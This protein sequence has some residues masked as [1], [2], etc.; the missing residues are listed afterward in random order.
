M[1]DDVTDFS[2]VIELAEF[3]GQKRPE[4]P[5]QLE[6]AFAHIEDAKRRLAAAADVAIT[7]AFA[8]ECD[9][10]IRALMEDLRAEG[11]R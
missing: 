5:E 2:E 4:N 9:A 8:R 10:D 3:Q 6:Q 7:T 1:R 11:Q